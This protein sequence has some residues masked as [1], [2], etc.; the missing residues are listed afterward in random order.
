M[1]KLVLKKDEFNSNIFELNFGYVDYYDP[2][3]QT[4]EI[5]DILNKSAYD[6]TG[7]KINSTDLNAMYNFQKAGFYVVDC[8][9]TYEYD[10]NN[11][12]PIS[13]EYSVS[14][15]ENVTQHEIVELASIA[16]SVFKIDRF[17]SDPN[18]KTELADKYYYQW[19][20]N[21]FNGFSDGAIVPVI[22]GKPVAFTTYKINN[23]S[24][25]TSTMVLSAVNPN[26]MGKGI[27]HNMIQKGTQYLLQ[28]SSKIRVGT[29]V[30]NIAV[31]RT[32]QK[33][34]YKMIDVKYILH[35]Y[36]KE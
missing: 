18:L 3:L 14:F 4:N 12:K 25:S 10:K 23:V 36:K 33:I 32:W 17:H 11:A 35:Y 21:S 2:S 15:K 8:L 29:Q 20:I 6:I 26:Y 31:Q 1:D 22:D 27:Y 5:L 16:R 24:E 34:G 30:D 28:F 19:V 13:D 9:V 7:I